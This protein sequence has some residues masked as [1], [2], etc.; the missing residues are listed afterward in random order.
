MWESAACSGGESTARKCYTDSPLAFYCN[1]SGLK[2]STKYYYS[3]G[4]DAV[5]TRLS[6]GD[7]SSGS[8]GTP[9]TGDISGASTVV[10]FD[11][12]GGSAGRLTARERFLRRRAAADAAA[13]KAYEDKLEAEKK[14]AAAAP[15]C[16]PASRSRA[17]WTLHP[18]RAVA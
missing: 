12:S 11:S 4:D 13:V 14:E 8:G 2:P 15:R 5:G 1:M 6:F 18:V 9:G 7:E 3:L 10:S 16:R 17:T